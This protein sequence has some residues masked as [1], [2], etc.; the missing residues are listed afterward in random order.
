MSASPFE[1]LAG[2]A[3]VYLAP[4]GES[5]PA[6]NAAPGGNWVSLG[7]TDGGVM[8]RPMQTVFPIRTDQSIN[9]RKYQRSESSFEVAFN[10]AT[11]TL[12][13]FAKVIDGKSVTD[14]AADTGVAG[15]RHL[16]LGYKVDMK[17]WAMLVRG[18]SPYMDA[19]LQWEL[20]QVVNIAASPEMSHNRTG[21]TVLACQFAAIKDPNASND[22]S[23]YGRLVAQDAAPV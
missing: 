7:E 19:N 2:P 8:V 4:V 5:M 9:V 12:E 11:L 23:A 15:Y 18:P 14:V 10:L 1:L 16:P 6:I 20:K 22:D 3:L 17:Q 21:L 13:N